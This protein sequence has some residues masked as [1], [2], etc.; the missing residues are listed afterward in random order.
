M[1]LSLQNLVNLRSGAGG[2]V[3]GSITATQDA[4]TASLSGSVTVSGVS[5]AITANQAANTASLTGAEIFSGSITAN[6]SAN[7]ASLT[8]AGLFQGSITASQAANTASVSGS[9]TGAGTSGS[10]TASQAANTASLTGSETFAGG[11]TALQAGNTAS[12][13]GSV[14]GGAISGVIT[15]QQDDQTASLIGSGGQI[16]AGGYDDKPKKRF[17]VERDGKLI[18]FTT[19]QSAMSAMVEKVEKQEVLPPLLETK[20][21]EAVRT[22]SEDVQPQE[23]DLSAVQ[24]YA[25]IAGLIDQYNAA[26]NSARYEALIALFEQMQDEEDVEM[27][28]LWA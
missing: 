21:E 13:T 19:A 27:L 10:I 7:T 11:I 5:G 12:I 26:Y 18:V 24:E 23:I 25:R 8:G 6:Q 14:A 28:L 3:A 1:L 22:Q 17:I 15:A 20:E 4:N 9:V 2:S 16:A